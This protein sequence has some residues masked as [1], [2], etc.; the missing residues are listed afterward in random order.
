M[1]L[2]VLHVNGERTW[3]GGERQLYLQLKYTSPSIESHVMCR[4][5]SALSERISELPVRRHFSRLKNGFDLRSAWQ[6]SR[7][8]R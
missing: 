6:L 5:G 8:C 4:R 3:R 7:L 1:T 2:K